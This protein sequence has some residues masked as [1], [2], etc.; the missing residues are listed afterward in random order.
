M[1]VILCLHVSA[2]WMHCACEVCIITCE[3]YIGMKNVSEKH[4]GRKWNTFYT[5]SANWKY[6]YNNGFEHRINLFVYMSS[7]DFV[8]CCLFLGDRPWR[9]THETKTAWF[10]CWETV[11][12]LSLGT[13]WH[14]FELQEFIQNGPSL[15][16]GVDGEGEEEMEEN[17]SEWEG[18]GR[19]RWKR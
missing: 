9:Y 1:P 6:S 2:Q 19:G 3:T 4:I 10:P 11:I 15:L 14:V 5:K 7:S 13:S 12:F 16:A 18:R 8:Y 17:Q